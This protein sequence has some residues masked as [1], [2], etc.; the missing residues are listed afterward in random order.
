MKFTDLNLSE[1]I[2]KAIDD[3]GYSIPT[4]IQKQAIPVLLEGF[5]CL[6]QAQTG[7]GKTAAFGIPIIEK[8]SQ[9]NAGVEA[10]IMA[11][12][13]ELVVQIVDALRDFSSYKKL[14]I[15]TIIGGVAYSRQLAMLKNNPNIIVA[16]PG[17]IIDHLENKK[18]NLNSLKMFCIDEADE[19]LKV[20]FKEEIDKIISY[21]PKKKQS[22]L[23]SATLDKDVRKIAEKAMNSPKEILVSSGLATVETVEQ[24]SVIVDEKD[25]LKILTNILDIKSGEKSLVF[26]RTKKRADELATAL[27]SLGYSSRALHGDLNQRQRLHVVNEFRM[28][29]F[30]ILVATDVAARGIDISGIKY[31]YNFDLP[32]EVEYYVHRIGRTGRA[33]EKGVSF[34]FIRQNEMPH[35][36]R[37]EKET[38]TKIKIVLPPTREELH[39]S[40]QSVAIDK[41]VDGVDLGMKRLKR[42][43]GVAKKLIEKYGGEVALAAAVEVLIDRKSIEIPELSKEPSVKIKSN[44]SRSSRGGS[45][46]RKVNDRS[47]YKRKSS[48][49]N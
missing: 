12:T 26:G 2:K 22:M 36:K 8:C 33:N 3:L 46:K 49:K 27:N 6:G 24:F 38:N 21:L 42:H 41:I 39:I 40:Q 48:R 30:D 47:Y 32:Q 18:I 15:A 43:I 29:G 13:R 10:L 7:T 34:S 9:K 11:P 14:R 44:N 25:K 37:I 4:D 23:F 5:D 20:G 28:G 16:T 31:V 17:R 19:M 45:R 35:L 1:E